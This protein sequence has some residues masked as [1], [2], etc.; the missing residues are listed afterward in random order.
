MYGSSVTA[1]KAETI[2]VSFTG[3]VEKQTMVQP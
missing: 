3:K 1:K 2:Q